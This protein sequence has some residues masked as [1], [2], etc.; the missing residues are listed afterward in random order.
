MISLSICTWSLN[1]GQLRKCFLTWSLILNLRFELGRDRNENFLRKQ[2]R[3]VLITILLAEPYYGVYI[4]LYVVDYLLGY[5]HKNQ[6]Y[7]HDPKRIRFSLDRN[8][9]HFFISFHL[10]SKKTG[11]QGLIFGGFFIQI[12]IVKYM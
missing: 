12:A 2:S 1:D 10:N 3:V 4:R 8:Q 5:S 9:G 11:S 7:S 6:T